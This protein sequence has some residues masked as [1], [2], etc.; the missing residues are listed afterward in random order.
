M[1]DIQK[2]SGRGLDNQLEQTLLFVRILN[3]GIVL[4][5]V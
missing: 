5:M 4:Y 1:Y 2:V 3:V